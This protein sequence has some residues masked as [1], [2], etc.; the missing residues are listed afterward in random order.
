MGK[1]NKLLKTKTTKMQ[2]TKAGEMRLNREAR[3]ARKDYDTQLKKFG[4]LQDNFICLPDPEDCY[5]WYYIVFGLEMEGFKGG[6]YLGKITCPP[7]YPAKAPNIRMITE[8]GRLHTTDSICMSISDMHPESWN[9]AWKVNQIVCG[10]L[11]MW[12]GDTEGTYGTVYEYNYQL[13]GKMTFTDKRMQLAKDSR[14]FTLNHEKFKIFE[15]YTEAI[16]INK[17]PDVPEWAAHTERME[18]YNEKL[19]EEKRIREEKANKEAEERKRQEEER[20]RA[21][22]KRL[23]EEQAKKEQEERQRQLKV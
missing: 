9:P 4:K 8:N 18:K 15:K 14:E 5:V 2:R 10:L 19:A 11:S 7:D 23:I 22:E 3:M 13:N 20:K 17:V 1:T 6:Y 16:G 21:E 12:L